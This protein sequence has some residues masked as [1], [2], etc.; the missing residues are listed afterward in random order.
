MELT[1]S[2]KQLLLQ[3]LNTEAS[4]LKRGVN[5]ACN[6]SIKEILQNQLFDLQDLTGRVS[7]EPPK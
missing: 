3:A 4:R 2:D 6:Q 1:V 5:T 7:K